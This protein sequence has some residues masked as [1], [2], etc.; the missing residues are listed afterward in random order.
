V[1]EVSCLLFPKL[2]DVVRDSSDRSAKVR[3]CVDSQIVM[4][5][6]HRCRL[7]WKLDDAK[8]NSQKMLGGVL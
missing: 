3:S 4:M 2:V 6:A 5:F 1:R 8:E 7:P